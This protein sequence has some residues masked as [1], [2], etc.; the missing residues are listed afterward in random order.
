MRLTPI[1]TALLRVLAALLVL[2]PLRAQAQDPDADAGA[3]DDSRAS[4]AQPSAPDASEAAPRRAH[5]EPKQ[6]D[7]KEEAEGISAL[8]VVA[9][10]P[11]SG[12]ILGGYAT[13]HFRWPGQP[14]SEP[15]ST[16]PLLAAVTTKK[17]LG[18]ELTPELFTVGKTYWLLGDVT[19]RWVPSTNYFGLGNDTELDDEEAYRAITFGLDTN[20]R[21]RVVEGVYV[22]VIQTLQWRGLADLKPDGLLDRERPAGVTGGWTSGIGAELAYDTRDNT[23]APHRGSYFLLSVPV[24]TPWLGSEWTFTRVLLDLRQ[25][26]QLTGEHILALRFSSEI[27][28]GDAPFDRLAELGGSGSLRGYVRGQF[29]DKQSVAL[30]VEYRFPIYWRFSGVAFIGT[31]QVAPN[32]GALAFD[33]WHVAGGVGLRFAIVPEERINVRLDVAAA[34]GAFRGYF[35]PRE[36][37]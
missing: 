14:S 29:R 31:G 6:D 23:S 35:A 19:A 10:L 22:G 16:V 3:P 24:H 12:L 32:M 15:A 27:V 21:R 8:P 4:D 20:V 2:M 18:F 11:E 17:E 5:A 37:Y 7:A 9:Y 36:A 26:V 33:R 34:P 13:Y 25:F 1:L 30:D 28:M